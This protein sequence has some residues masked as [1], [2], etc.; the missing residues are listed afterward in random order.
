[1]L[2]KEKYGFRI[3]SSIQAALYSVI[4]EI[5]KVMNNILSVGGLLCDLEKA[6]NCVNRAILVQKLKCYVISGSFPTLK[7][8]YL[9]GHNKN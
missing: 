6:F 2:V 4:S 1:M 5:S 9:I 3:N 7:P 8:S